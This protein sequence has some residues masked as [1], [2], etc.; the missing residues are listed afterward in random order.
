VNSLIHELVNA[1]KKKLGNSRLVY[2]NME[3][4]IDHFQT[5]DIR[6]YSSL[7]VDAILIQNY[8]NGNNFIAKI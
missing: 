3:N 7:N 8:D 1:I 5:M 4:P 2:F 6:L